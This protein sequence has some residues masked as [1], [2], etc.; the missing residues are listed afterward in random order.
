MCLRVEC[1]VGGGYIT[2]WVQEVFEKQEV[3]F[4]SWSFI[5]LVGC[6]FDS[7][8]AQLTGSWQFSGPGWVLLQGKVV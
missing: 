1:V 4:S 6:D 8:M 2:W 3:K 7:H 5:I